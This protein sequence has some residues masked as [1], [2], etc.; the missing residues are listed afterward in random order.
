[1]PC[2]LGSILFSFFTFLYFLAIAC[3]SASAM[4]FMRLIYAM[5]CYAM[6][7]Y[8][9]I[10]H[11]QYHASCFMLLM[12]GWMDRRSTLLYPTLLLLKSTSSSQ[13]IDRQTDR[14]MMIKLVLCAYLEPLCR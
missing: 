6:L 7:C 1:M 12:D 3:A 9:F 8:L 10:Y 14:Q 4:D 13:G 11:V 5:L 2:V